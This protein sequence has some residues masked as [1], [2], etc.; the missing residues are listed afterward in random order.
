MLRRQTLTKYQR[1]LLFALE[2]AR[3]RLAVAIAAETKSTPPERW[4][5]YF[6]TAERARQ[7]IKK[8]RCSNFALSE[9]RNGW[10]EAFEL[11][12]CFSSGREAAQL[13]KLLGEI[14]AKLE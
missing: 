7:F 1:D 11:L 5:N 12:K 6:E 14:V 2:A 4:Q 13:C 10:T 8:L 9:S 3:T